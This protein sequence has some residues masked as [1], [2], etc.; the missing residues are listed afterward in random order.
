LIVT[1]GIW[2]KTMGRSIF[3]HQRTYWIWRGRERVR[4]GPSPTQTFTRSAL[5]SDV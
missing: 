1:S 3:S 5:H 2:S 4:S